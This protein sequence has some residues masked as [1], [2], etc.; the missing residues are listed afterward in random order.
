MTSALSCL[1]AI[2]ERKLRTAAVKEL[3]L[4][5]GPVN[6]AQ[7][8]AMC[9][10]VVR[11]VELRRGISQLLDYRLRMDDIAAQLQRGSLATGKKRLLSESQKK[12][13]DSLT[14]LASSLQP[15]LQLV[16]N[17]EALLQ[18]GSAGR[19]LPLAPALSL[20]KATGQQL[21]DLLLQLPVRNHPNQAE[22]AGGAG[23]AAAG[24]AGG[25]AAGGVAAGRAGAAAARLRVGAAVG[26]AP[27]LPL[28][29]SAAVRQVVAAAH[30][31]M[32]AEEERQHLYFT[33]R[34]F[35][36]RTRTTYCNALTAIWMLQHVSA[37]VS[38]PFEAEAGETQ[39]L[40]AEAR[41]RLQ[42][43]QAVLTEIT[44]CCMDFNLD[45]FVEFH[46]GNVD[47]R[48]IRWPLQ[49]AMLE[50]NALQSQLWREAQD[51]NRRRAELNKTRINKLDKIVP[52]QDLN[53]AFD[54]ED[55]YDR[56]LQEAE[57]RLRA[58]TGSGDEDA[59]ST[60]GA[61]DVEHLRL[62]W[63]PADMVVR[64]TDTS[65]DAEAAVVDEIERE[66]GEV[67][68]ELEED[69]DGDEGSDNSEDELWALTAAEEVME[70]EDG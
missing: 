11:D 31:F 62:P 56:V 47:K 68:V 26:L 61:S 34:H 52:L 20:E 55:V 51:L 38:A 69:E 70:A 9:V 19:E 30:M 1:A 46:V 13:N 45:L 18:A 10:D 2:E 43:A 39:S 6:D 24:V 40:I 50:V 57:R 25:V 64:R 53:F 3:G 27:V 15:Q 66:G 60:A 54:D 32:R 35:A 8:R 65:Q 29:V 23:A 12:Y 28:A 16:M 42:L 59:L 37:V 33:V 21:H 14:K 48:A 22:A 5:A 7:L 63:D 44:G 67:E 49:R 58:L 4:A 41:Q 17:S 36:L